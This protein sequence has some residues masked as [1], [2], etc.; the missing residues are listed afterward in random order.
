MKR[1]G[2]H[3]RSRGGGKE[4]VMGTRERQARAWLGAWVIVGDGGP[5]ATQCTGVNDG[6]ERERTLGSGEWWWRQS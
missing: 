4:P 2:P 3:I 5:T 6:R 1:W